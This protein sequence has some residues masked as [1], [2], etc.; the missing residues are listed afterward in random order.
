MGG[1]TSSVAAK[2]AFFPPDPPSYG[3]VDEE[4]PPPSGA[5]PAATVTAV[6]QSDAAKISSRVAM[7]GVPWRE[8]VEARR[9]RTRRGSEIIA[10]YVRCPKASLTVLYSHGNAADLGKMYEL[11][12]EF[13]ARLHVNV[14][15]YDYSGYGRS[16][17]KASEANTFADI[18]A[19]YKCLVEVYGTRGEDIVLYG[20]SVGSGP[21]IDL[22]ARLHHIR[23]VVLHSPI[24]SGLRVMYSS[25]KKTYWFDI[26]KNIEKIPRVKCPVLVIHGTNDDVVDC[27]HG[28]RLWELSQQKYEPLWIEGG[29]HCNLETFPVYIR[30]LKKFL[31]AI[32]KLPIGKEAPANTEKLPAENETPSDRALSEAPWTTSQRLEPSRKSSRHEQPPGPSTEHVDK[33]RRSTGVRE[34]SRSSTDRRERSRR[35][36]VDTFERAT[37]D[38][39]EQTDKPRKSIDR[40]GEMIRSMGLCNVDCF[41]DPPRKTEPSIGQS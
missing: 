6:A 18:E 17:G 37:I 38:E 20:Q 7:T 41:K 14:M 39:N 26:Y 9:V 5:A 40:L 34:K 27:S 11:F 25:V 32:E 36:S 30:H 8:G 28:K 24:L 23:A 29:D 2:F 21:T 4:E 13:S 3:V 15:G 22:A 10:M 12:I 19:A 1:V 35:R 16:S 33:H 31:S